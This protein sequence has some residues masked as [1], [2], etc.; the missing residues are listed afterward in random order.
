MSSFVSYSTDRRVDQGFTD[1]IIRDIT[2]KNPTRSA[3][4]YTSFVNAIAP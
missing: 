4:F 1:I 2:A 3:E